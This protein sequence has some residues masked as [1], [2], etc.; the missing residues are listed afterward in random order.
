MLGLFTAL[1]TLT[2]LAAGRTA[3]RC[4]ATARQEDF[5]G[6]TTSMFLELP[7]GERGAGG[8]PETA[9]APRFERIAALGT[10]QTALNRDRTRTDNLMYFN[11]SC[12]RPS[13]LTEMCPTTQSDWGDGLWLVDELAPSSESV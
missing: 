5:Y 8:S 3:G 11:S 6:L 7:K 2:D 4:W 9:P 10:G 1:A 13:H 12:Q